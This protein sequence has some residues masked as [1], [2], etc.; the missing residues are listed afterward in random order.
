MTCMLMHIFLLVLKYATK[1]LLLM[2]YHGEHKI[3]FLA[4]QSA[5]I[6]YDLQRAVYRQ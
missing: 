4:K 6:H 1:H 5:V 3:L 2:A